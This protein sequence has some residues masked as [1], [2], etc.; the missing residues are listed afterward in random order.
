M[1]IVYKIDVLKALKDK[2]FSTY[3]LRKEKLLSEGMIQALRD[4]R[5][6]SWDNLEK[7]CRLLQC[8]PSDLIEYVEEEQ[9]EEVGT[10]ESR[11]VVM[12][13]KKPVIME[14][15]SR[16]VF[17]DI[18][19]YIE[20]DLSKPQGAIVTTL[21]GLQAQFMEQLHD[22]DVLEIY[23]KSILEGEKK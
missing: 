21:N 8:Q 20:F 12:V 3:N 11:I 23:W 10:N 17:V 7:L 22:G 2:G 13:N 18:F 19:D 14:G 9:K 16:Y 4:K 5:P 1:P 6:I 15:K